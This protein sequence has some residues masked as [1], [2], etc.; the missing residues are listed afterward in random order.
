[1][2]EP[3]RVQPV[4]PEQEIRGVKNSTLDGFSHVKI[5]IDGS[6]NEF[7]EKCCGHIHRHWISQFDPAINP[8]YPE[9]AQSL[10]H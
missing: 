8:S 10:R 5:G 1:M 7:V 4:T 2:Q 3:T 9:V 6:N